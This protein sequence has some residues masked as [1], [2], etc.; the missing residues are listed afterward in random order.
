[1]RKISVIIKRPGKKPCRT[2]ISDTLENLQNTVG[3]YIEKVTLTLDSCIIGNE[4][5]LLIGLPYNCDICGVHFFGT[6]IFIGVDGDK[7]TDYPASWST[8]RRMHSN[9]FEEEHNK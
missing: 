4:E 3:G 7:F 8:F 1:M 9:L 2:Y 6:I 5:G